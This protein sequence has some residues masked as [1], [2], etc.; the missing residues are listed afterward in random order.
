MQ[1]SEIGMIGLGTMGRNL[2][3][4]IGDKGFSAAGYDKDFN[5]LQLLEKEA[6]ERKITAAKSLEEFFSMLKKP[7]A[8][9][10]LVPAGSAVDAIIEEALPYMEK[11]DI[12]IDGGNSHFTDTDRRIKDLEG[13]NIHFMGL[14]ISGGEQGARLGP[15]MMPGGDKEAY[16]RLKN[17]FEAL[18]AKVDG[19][20]CVGYMGHGSA[21]HYV[22]MVHNGIEYALIQLISESYHLLKTLGLNN[23]S[24][25][26]IFEQWNNQELRS[27]LIE[28][29]AGIFRKDEEAEM[30]GKNKNRRRLIDLIMD[31]ARQKGTG[32]WTS[33]DAMNLQVPVP[34]IDAAVM[35][36]DLS[37]DRDMRIKCSS[38][39]KGPSPEYNGNKEEFTRR[40]KNA[41]YFAMI[42]SYSQGLALL[43]KA[44][45]SYGYETDLR[46]VASIWRGGC[47]I[48]ASVLNDMLSAFAKAPDLSNLI[49]DANFSGILNSHQSDIRFIAGS[50]IS[51]GI[52]VPALLASLSYFDSYRSRWLPA[53]LVQAQRDYFGAH[54]YERMD[55]KGIFHTE[56]L[57]E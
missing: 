24:L 12:I 40:L 51:M 45:E 1:Q 3:L 22:K 42:T 46:K 5:K 54:T 11:G 2:V 34:T 18:S 35:M 27:F 47:I 21:G 16:S 37:A 38:I 15:S 8:F 23:D 28:I 52:P 56:W 14:G 53:N 25:A 49:S 44:S 39:L 41:L 26:D 55:K 7:R 20:A 31:R 33:Q 19:E 48:R 13:R 10:M 29:T 9:I 4:N 17:V 57:K 32:K 50:A 36:R 43:K 6:G 30:A